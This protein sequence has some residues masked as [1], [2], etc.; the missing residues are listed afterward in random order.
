M[1]IKNSPN[2]HA[3]K[4]LFEGFTVAIIAVN[5]VRKWNWSGLVTMKQRE[6]Q[7]CQRRHERKHSTL[8][9]MGK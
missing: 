7:R 6:R 2:V 9:D 5:D 8:A 1:L 3:Q 4:D